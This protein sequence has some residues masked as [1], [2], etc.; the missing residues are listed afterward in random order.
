MT[1]S[2]Y[3][4]VAG[5]NG[6]NLLREVFMDNYVVPEHLAM[7]KQPSQER[8]RRLV[9][10]ILDSTLSLIQEQGMAAVNTNLIAQ[11]AE[12]DIASLYRFFKNK[13]AIFFSLAMR[14]FKKVQIVV[15]DVNFQQTLGNIV[16]Y[17]DSAQSKI[18]ALDET[19]VMLVS[20]HELFTHDKDFKA[21]ESWHRVIVIEQTKRSFISHGSKWD[22]EALTSVCL[23]LYGL[24]RNFMAGTIG[25]SAEE[26][27]HQFTWFQIMLN[28]LR[29]MVLLEKVPEK[30]L[31]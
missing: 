15:E 1:T 7:R 19:E 25:F 28:Q 24:T 3:V 14:W 17:P 29:K 23:Y 9:E 26:H 5:K 30:F 2:V 11:H 20:F 18:N 31:R 4:E 27:H 13:E 6:I 21:L 12:I 22:D 16:E 8:T 10:H